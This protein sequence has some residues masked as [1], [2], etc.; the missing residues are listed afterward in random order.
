MSIARSMIMICLCVYTMLT[1][2]NIA[3][4][5]TNNL[6]LDAEE[7]E[8]CMPWQGKEPDGLLVFHFIDS[9]M[10]TEIDSVDVIM[11]TSGGNYGRPMRKKRS[12]W[13]SPSKQSFKFELSGYLSVIVDD[14]RVPVDSAIIVTLQMEKGEGIVQ[15]GVGGDSRVQVVTVSLDGAVP[16]NEI[17]GRII[18]GSNGTPIPGATIFCEETDQTESTDSLGEFTIG[19]SLLKSVRLNAWHPLYDSVRFEINKDYIRTSK[20]IEISF[21]TQRRTM[22]GETIDSHSDSTI[23]LLVDMMMWGSRMLPHEFSNKIYTYEV[24]PGEVFGPVMDWVYYDCIPFRLIRELPD[25]S[26]WVQFSD[27]FRLITGTSGRKTNYTFL[28]D[29]I[30]KLSTNS[31]DAGIIVSLSLQPDYSPRGQIRQDVYRGRGYHPIPN[32]ESDVDSCNIFKAQVERIHLGNMFAM[33]DGDFIRYAQACSKSYNPREN[34]QYMPL[35][36]FFKLIFESPSHRKFSDKRILELFKLRSAEMYVHGI[37]AEPANEK[38]LEGCKRRQFD[39]QKGDVYIDWPG[40]AF[41]GGLRAVYR[42]ENERWKI[43]ETF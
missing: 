18:D 30:T 43:V 19:L 27:D 21:Q 2:P 35:E 11:K 1:T 7:V 38:F 29:S 23:L 20:K 9:E 13:M 10:Q 40:I 17:N 42:K 34:K 22:K 3:T 16:K 12:Y 39:P 24:L 32:K 36:D 37:C 14:I 28:S 15:A 5:E 6:S 31:Y 26:A 25:E 33:L 41:H 8:Q 4:S